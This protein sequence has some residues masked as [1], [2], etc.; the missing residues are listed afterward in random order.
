MPLVPRDRRPSKADTL[1]AAAQYIRLLRGV[2]RDAGGCQVGTP[3]PT[4]DPPIRWDFG[5]LVE[6]SLLFFTLELIIQFIF[7]LL[8]FCGAPQN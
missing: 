3:K 4:P 8:S 6:V 5:R 7:K 1:R 2:L